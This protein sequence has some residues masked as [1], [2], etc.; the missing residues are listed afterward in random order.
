MQNQTAHTLG[1]D[2]W[3]WEGKMPLTLR[4]EEI[5]FFSILKYC[6][7][8]LSVIIII[9]WSLLQKENTYVNGI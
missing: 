8:F 4:P 6:F 7:V 5:L 2:G 9:C 3:G 1:K